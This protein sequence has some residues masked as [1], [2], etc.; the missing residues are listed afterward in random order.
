M[1][2]IGDE[3]IHSTTGE[4]IVVISVNGYDYTVQNKAKVQYYLSVPALCAEMGW[5]PLFGTSPSIQ[6]CD[7]G[8][9]FAKDGGKHSD[10]CSVK[11]DNV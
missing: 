11:N 5:V 6:K 2:K 3:F 4:R 7:C 1:P 10:W 9:K 8:L